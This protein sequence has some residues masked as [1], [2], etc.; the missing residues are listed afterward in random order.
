LVMLCCV[1]FLITVITMVYLVDQI[2]AFGNC[3]TTLM[4]EQVGIGFIRA[5]YATYVNY[6]PIRSFLK[7]CY[8][9]LTLV[10]Y[11]FRCLKPTITDNLVSSQ[12]ILVLRGAAT[13]ITL[14]QRNSW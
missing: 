9:T 7:Q 14:K 3:R 5:L 8:G 6:L 4:T 10:V 11:L 12:P 2:H 1:D 13:T